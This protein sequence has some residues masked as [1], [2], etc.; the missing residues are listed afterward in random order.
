MKEL[1]NGRLAV[2]GVNMSIVDVVL[3]FILMLFVFIFGK[4]FLLLFYERAWKRDVRVRV[5]I[6]QCWRLYSAWLGSFVSQRLHV[7]FCSDILS[8][9]PKLPK[10]ITNESFPRKVGN[11]W[12]FV[13]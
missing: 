8:I 12:I 4:G 6:R 7:C 13:V 5:Y 10:Q 9:S 11:F 3:C 2:S 1:G